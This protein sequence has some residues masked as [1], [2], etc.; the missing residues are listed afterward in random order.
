MKVLDW[1]NTFRKFF[2][3][4]TLK[5]LIPETNC[6]EQADYFIFPEELHFVDTNGVMIKYS[7]NIKV[8]IVRYFKDYRMIEKQ[9]MLL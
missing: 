5:K 7:P 4:R 8:Y 3:R 6:I 2:V 9:Y 1:V